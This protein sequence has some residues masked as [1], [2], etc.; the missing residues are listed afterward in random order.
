MLLNDHG[1]QWRTL[2]DLKRAELHGGGGLIRRQQARLD[3]ILSHA[4]THSR[5][6]QRHHAGHP[7]DALALRDLPAVTKPRLMAAF[8]E[9]VTDPIITRRAL[10]AFIAQPSLIGAPYMDRFF[11]CTS[12]GTTG[13]P[14]LF[15]HD[16]HAVGVYL[17]INTAR[18]TPAWFS[19]KQLMHIVQG[20]FRWAA[21]LGTQSH[22]VGASWLAQ[23]QRRGGWRSRGIRVFPVQQRLETLMAELQ[24]FDPVLLTGY[25]SVIRLLAHEQL[26]GR[27][28]LKLVAV[29]LSGESM[30]PDTHAQISAAFACPVRDLYAASECPSMA[31]AVTM[32]GFISTATGSCLSRSKRT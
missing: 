32:G 11:V 25:P 31:L 16:R 12:S 17:A 24:A 10:E 8:D 26:A 28:N 23:E 19:A 4:R 3:A 21:V 22:Y 29:E 20:G 9:W 15:V 14:G 13:H 6:Y 5:F 2:L 27:L 18:I 30:S 1:I 7:S